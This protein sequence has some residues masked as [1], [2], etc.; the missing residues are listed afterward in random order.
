MADAKDAF[1]AR[2]PEGSKLEQQA[3]L[4]RAEGELGSEVL[5]CA[6]AA[7]DSTD[8]IFEKLR[9]T[10]AEHFRL[11]RCIEQR[12]EVPV[13]FVTMT[14]A[15]HHWQDLAAVLQEYEAGT[16]ACR[17]GRRDLLEPGEHNIDP[18]KLRVMHYTGDAGTPQ[19]HMILICL[20]T[21]N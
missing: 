10:T 21:W 8:E 12:G 6:G 2:A 9:Q 19:H 7:N 15:T 13:H 14:T 1:V 3:D 20:R 17:G 18:D 11:R 16:S 4:E 5:A